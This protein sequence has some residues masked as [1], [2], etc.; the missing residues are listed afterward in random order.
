MIRAHTQRNIYGQLLRRIFLTKILKDNVN[1]KCFLNIYIIAHSFVSYHVTPIILTL[2]KCFNIKMPFI[3][4][5]FWTFSCQQKRKIID[6]NGQEKQRNLPTVIM[7]TG[8]K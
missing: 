3:I 5:A 6:Q 7:L 4:A 8:K 1:F 2:K